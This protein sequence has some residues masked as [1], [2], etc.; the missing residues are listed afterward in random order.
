MII[1]T[2]EPFFFPGNQI[3]CLLV[4]GFTGSPKEM[5]W[6]GEYLGNLGYTV[7]GVRLAGHATRPEDMMRMQ[8]Q[9]WLASVE[10]GYFLLKNCVDQVFIIGLS[11]GG[12]LS[13]TF[14]SQH[15]FLALSA[16]QLHM[17]FQMTL[18]YLLSGLFHCSYPKWKK[19]LPIGITRRQLKIMW[20]TPTTPR[21]HSYSFVIY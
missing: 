18:A 11:M 15:P 2:A 3:G 20:I 19:A 12:I 17:L 13:L 7:L 21:S 16:C 9:D 6:M 8:W 1:P 14:S 5:R 10:D 4:H